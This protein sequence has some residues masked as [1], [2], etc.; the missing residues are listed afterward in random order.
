MRSRCLW[1]TL[2][3]RCLMAAALMLM[4]WCARGL[5]RVQPPHEGSACPCA[6][7]ESRCALAISQSTAPHSQPSP[8]ELCCLSSCDQR[9]SLRSTEH[10]HRQ[11]LSI[12]TAPAA[13]AAAVQVE[14]CDVPNGFL[15][16][17]S[18]AGGTGAGLGT[19]VA[20]ALRDE[21]PSTH[22]LNC[23]V[24]PYE[25]GEVIVQVWRAYVRVWLL[26]VLASAAGHC[27]SAAGRC[28]SVACSCSL[29][30]TSDQ[31]TGGTH[32]RSH[33]CALSIVLVGLES[34]TCVCT[35]ACEECPCTFAF[36]QSQ[37]VLDAQVV[38]AHFDLPRISSHVSPCT[39]CTRPDVC[40][41][42][43]M[44]CRHRRRPTRALKAALLQSLNMLLTPTELQ[45]A[46]HTCRAYK[47]LQ[48]AAHPYRACKDLLHAAHPCRAY[49]ELQYAVHPY[50]ACKELQH[51]AHLR[52]ARTELQHAA[53]PC[54]AST[55]WLTPQS[56]NTL[57]TLSHLHGVSDGIITLENDALHRCCTRL[58][59]I[60]RPSFAVRSH[61]QESFTPLGLSAAP[62]VSGARTLT[63]YDC[64]PAIRAVGRRGCSSVAA[65]GPPTPCSLAPCPC[66][67]PNTMCGCPSRLSLVLRCMGWR[68]ALM[69]K[70][71]T[72]SPFVVFSRKYGVR[73]CSD[74]HVR[75]PHSRMFLSHMVALRTPC[76]FH[77]TYIPLIKRRSPWI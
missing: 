60:P 46:A 50:R 17:Q 72:P 52:R 43:C 5:N 7:E 18:M 29:P 42:A 8:P 65:H 16:L 32:T 25:S 19:Y 64:Y 11:A 57:L 73:M 71:L 76:S 26:A 30:R 63:P 53:H 28:A 45:H 27:V 39:R 33:L 51:A 70:P 10:V 62:S 15:L 31:C 58:M 37:V 6:R 20:T 23:C 35:S 9:G 40:V 44:L 61:R 3:R 69:P 24:W 55:R 21:F 56:Y 1:L 4:A 66:S 34:C 59:N 22:T 74:A 14:A 48:Y 38:Q 47:E 54:R 77:N 2:C 41:C 68:T 49:K 12:D 36:L 13:A 75:Y 67:H